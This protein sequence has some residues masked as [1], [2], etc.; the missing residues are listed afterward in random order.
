LYSVCNKNVGGEEV[1]IL[2]HWKYWLNLVLGGEAVRL[3]TSV[4]I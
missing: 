2:C 1:Q 4:T 3:T